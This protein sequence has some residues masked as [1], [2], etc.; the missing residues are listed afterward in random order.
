MTTLPCTT[1]YR[2]L[3][4]EVG[5]TRYNRTCI[6]AN[7]SSY[8]IQMVVRD[9]RNTKNEVGSVFSYPKCDK[10]KANITFFQPLS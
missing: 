6:P 2:E 1:A 5:T 4:V 7:Q 10:E 3:S 8:L 9:S